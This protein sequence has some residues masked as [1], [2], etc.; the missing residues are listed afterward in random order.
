MLDFTIGNALMLIPLLSIFG[1]FLWL[2]VFLQSYRHFPQMDSRERIIMSV[3][4]ATFL[5]VAFMGLASL[6]L[7]LMAQRLV[8]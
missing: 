5:A 6:F 7:L 4:T 8:A 2:Q 3:T 1:G